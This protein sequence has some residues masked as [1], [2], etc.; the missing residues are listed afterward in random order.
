MNKNLHK[1]AAGELADAKMVMAEIEVFLTQG[2]WRAAARDAYLVALRS[3][4][5][6]ILAA[7]RELPQSHS[8]VNAIIALLYSDSTFKPATVLSSLEKWKNAG[9]YGHGALPMPEQAA[10]AFR[11][12][13]AY[14]ERMEKDI[15]PPEQG[16]PPL[17]QG[18][19]APRFAAK[20][21]EGWRRNHSGRGGIGD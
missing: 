2:H 16:G 9:D 3:S 13:K 17:G 6:R 8:G 21:K 18:A 10:H 4:H 5:A 12:A 19:P 15:G 1:T 20:V 7:G 11:T 14:L